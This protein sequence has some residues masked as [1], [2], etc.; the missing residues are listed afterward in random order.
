MFASQL[1]VHEALWLRQ[2]RLLEGFLGGAAPNVL[3]E[4]FLR[5][6][7][8]ARRKEVT[9]VDLRAKTTRKVA[10]VSK[11]VFKKS[12]G[13]TG[14]SGGLDRMKSRMMSWASFFTFGGIFPSTM[15]CT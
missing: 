11:E 2:R 5:G 1:T 8:A 14:F 12:A 7:G 15:T 4:K 3:H 13:F 10:K 6:G 9:A